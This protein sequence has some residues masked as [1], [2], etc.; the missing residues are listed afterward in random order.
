[1]RRS[2]FSAPFLEGR[3]KIGW[4]GKGIDTMK[5]KDMLMS[6]ETIFRDEQVFNPNYLPDTILY[7]DTELQALIA[8]LKPGLRGGKPHNTL[9][10]GPPGTGKTTTVHTLFSEIEAASDRM[11]PVHINCKLSNTKFAV[12]SE[13]HKKLFG[14]RPPETGVPYTRVYAKVMT[15]LERKGVSLVVA[16]DDIDFL[17]EQKYA[18]DI[19]YAILRAYEQFPGVR[20]GVIAMLSREDFKEV[21]ATKLY[22]IFM[23]QEVSFAPYS[24][25]E[26]YE[27][28]S[29]RAAAGFYPGVI[30]PELVEYIATLTAS[31]GDLR[32]GINLLSSSGILAERDARKVIERGDV[33]AAYEKK[34]RFV[35]LK[36]K[37]GV[38]SQ[39][40]R[41]ILMEIARNPDVRSG[42]LQDRMGDRV[43]KK[44]FS[45]AMA[46]LESYAL[47][48]S[49]VILVG[50]G[51]SRVFTLKFPAEDV[52][53]VLNEMVKR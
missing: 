44:S 22:S 28:L 49:T 43:N 11:V 17:F 30:S 40:E 15:H 46:K 48:D 26:V 31:H 41:D 19:M 34:A 23:P 20:T 51:R 33:E 10:I 36:E 50:K 4:H 16:L 13:I 21:L 38:L 42:V 8:L 47:V 29:A 14:F 25:T 24:L 7:R 35:T 12:I 18:N 27:I 1:M 3:V 37:V 53:I 2:G 45:Q 39:L 52:I 5:I 6:D 9:V 32:V